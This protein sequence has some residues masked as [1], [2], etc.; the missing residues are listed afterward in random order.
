VTRLLSAST[1]IT[2]NLID[3]MQYS[4]HGSVQHRT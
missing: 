2:D 3:N 4:N 1:H